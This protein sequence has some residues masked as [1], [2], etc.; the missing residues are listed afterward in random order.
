MDNTFT[1][2]LNNLLSQ[3]SLISILRDGNYKVLGR[4]GSKYTVQCPFHKDG[5]ETNPS[6]SV[7]DSKGLYQCFT[8]GAKGNIITYLKEKDGLS[9]KDSI[10]Y[11]GKRF[12]IDVS[13]FFS[14]QKSRNAYIHEESVRINNL[15]MKFFGASLFSKDVNGEYIYKE[16]VDYLKKRKL[17]LDII[18]KFK[19]G[20]APPT[21]DGLLKSLSEH[22]VSNKNMAALGLIKENKTGNFRDTFINRIMFPIM[23]ERGEVIGFGGRVID[24]SEPKY[25]NSK[26]SFVFKK[27]NTLYAINLAKQDIMREDSVVV[28][29]G[30]MDAIACHK[31]GVYN[32]VANLGTAITDEHVQGIKKY[33]KNVVFALDSDEAGIKA[34]KLAIFNALKFDMSISV[35]TLEKYKDFDEF[36]TKEGATSYKL[37]YDR[38]ISWY[39]WLIKVELRG[40]EMANLSVENR[41]YI[42][43]TFSRYLSVIKLESYKDLVIS[44]LAEK[45]SIRKESLYRD[46]SNVT[47]EYQSRP[48]VVNQNTEKPKNV[49][50]LNFENSLIYLLVINPSLIGKISSIVE[51]NLICNERVREYY[52]RLLTL[53]DKATVED[54]LS[55]LGSEKVKQSIINKKHLYTDNIEEKLES[56]ILK[57]KENN[58]NLKRKEI[59]QSDNTITKT[60]DD[61]FQTARLKAREI[62]LLNKEKEKLYDDRRL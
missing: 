35:I 33:T 34:T 53:N 47:N 59:L 31:N 40:T 29:E 46:Q 45:L 12:S 1:Q 42:T 57:I 60:N 24:G 52:I 55:V 2:K 21:W 27:K 48:T 39:D 17:P 26:E 43:S 20:Y 5:K 28:V 61:I 16:A 51:P 30:Y 7:D 8:C 49:Q 25:L 36:F 22:N 32:V 54:A 13:D 58:I 10:N 6:L 41:M 38:R 19:I 50:A 9:F 15:A 56:I 11:L 62:I 4:G 37:L 3:V 14:K 18:K 44:Y 23:N